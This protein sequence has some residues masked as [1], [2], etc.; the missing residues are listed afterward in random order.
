MLSSFK[1]ILLWQNNEIPLDHTLNKLKFW[2]Y[3]VK[4]LKDKSINMIFCS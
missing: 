3:N 1:T 4:E 2:N